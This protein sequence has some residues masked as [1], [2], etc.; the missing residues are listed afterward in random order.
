MESEVGNQNRHERDHKDLHGKARF[1]VPIPCRK[2]L[3]NARANE[4]ERHGVGAH[5]PFA[6]LLDVT[7]ACS[8]KGS[9]RCNNPGSSLDKGRG[10][11]VDGV[12]IVTM[13]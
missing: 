3:Q 4:G 6:V 2:G 12:G 13:V 9:G 10:Y 8:K 1:A 5:H 7:I 11:E